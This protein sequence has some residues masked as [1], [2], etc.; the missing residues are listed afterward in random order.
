MLG[1]LSTIGAAVA[2]AVV[3]IVKV[4]KAATTVIATV[5]R[6]PADIATFVATK[7][8]ASAVTATTVGKVASIASG[9]VA[10]TAIDHAISNWPKAVQVP[11]KLITQI[12]IS[13]AIYTKGANMGYKQS[14]ASFAK[15]YNSKK[16]K[17]V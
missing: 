17:I 12:G 3:A 7:A 15:Y 4:A 2:K 14:E 9:I 8:G 6:V 11:V 16:T 5:T 10:T 1:V 13:K